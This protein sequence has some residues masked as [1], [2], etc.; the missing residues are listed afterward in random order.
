MDGLSPH[1]A[2]LKYVLMDQHNAAAVL[3][4]TTI[5][6]LEECAAVMGTALSEKDLDALRLY[7]SHLQRRICTMCGGCIGEC[8]HGVAHG[9]LLRAMM[10]YD[11]YKDVNLAKEVLHTGDSLQKVRQCSDCLS[12]AV[13]CRRGLNIHAQL[14]A[15]HRM[16]G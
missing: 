10:Y 12:C 4:V 9:D 2:A 1:Q 3:G 14:K 13:K 5:E 8:P 16:F 11:G 6:Q 7:H 15:V